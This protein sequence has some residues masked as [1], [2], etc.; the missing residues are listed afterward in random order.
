MREADEYIRGKFEEYYRHN[1]GRV[2]PPPEMEKR[3]FGFLLFEEGIMI[4]HKAFKKATDLQSFIRTKVPAH[5]YNS[6]A[7]YLEP[8][9]EMDKKNWQGA[10]LTFDVDADHI[11]TTCKDAHDRWTCKN[12]K[13]QGKGSAPEKCPKC[14]GE[15]MDE[16]VW[17]CE[18]CL[19]RAKE[20]VIKL[21]DF[22]MNDFGFSRKNMIICFSGHRGYHV[23]LRADEVRSLD[24]DMRKEIVDYVLGLGFDSD[25]HPDLLRGNLYPADQNIKDR[26]WRGRIYRGTYEILTENSED[27][28][29]NMGLDR[30]MARSIV[31]RRDEFASTWIGEQKVPPSGISPTKWKTVI[32]K[33]VEL[34]GG[35]VDTVVTTDVHRLIRLPETLNAKTGFKAMEVNSIE[36]FDPFGDAIAFEGEETVYVRDAPQ[37]RVGDQSFGPYLDKTVTIP[38][39]AAILLV[40]KGKALPRR[41]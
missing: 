34:G 14:Q 21:L 36:S 27:E 38:S 41:D 13:T 1:F 16:E 12:C 24:S 30:R 33:A 2:R 29:V 22:L 10:D 20:E 39:A 3:E 8:D 35:K 7:Y 19:E 15:R 17:L 37:F 23:H 6:T 31:R 11:E 28:L 5:V 32:Q 40:A 18:I 4:R 9:Q 26:G 25:L